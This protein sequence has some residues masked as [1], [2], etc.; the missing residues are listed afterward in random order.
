MHNG[1]KF[2]LKVFVD[3]LNSVLVFL[4]H[5]SCYLD[6]LLNVEIVNEYQMTFLMML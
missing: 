6:A 2:A 5:G 4:M 1:L 3:F